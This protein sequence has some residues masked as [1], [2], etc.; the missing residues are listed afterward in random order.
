VRAVILAGGRGTRL[1]PYTT[2]LPKPLMPVGDRPI[3]ELLLA[4]LRDAG[5]ERATLAVGHLAPLIRAYF[6]D[7]ERFGV[8][9][10]Y[11]EEDA[12]LGTAGPIRL[13]AG[14]SET[15]LMMNGDLL[16]D[17]LFDRLVAH[18]RTTGAAA[19]VGL[20]RR[21]VRV[22]LGVI[23][24]DGAGFVTGY[25]EKPTWQYLASM[26]VYALEPSVLSYV[27]AAGPFDLPDL[28]RALVAAG[29]RVAG[30]VHEGYW[31]DIGR[32]ED[33]ERAQS[34]IAEGRFPLGG[35]PA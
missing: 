23:D 25:T 1:A 34:D 32:P 12:P 29:Q 33:Y 26:G 2:V 8:K 24:L 28:V 30:F 15:F 22:S 3:L 35:G 17:L 9:I 20:C 18:H 16:T 27:P 21:D 14:L 11:S 4:R 6:G 5:V 31:L 7:G 13:V 10:D 19:T